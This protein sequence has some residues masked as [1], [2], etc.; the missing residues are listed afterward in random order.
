MNLECLFS[1]VSGGGG[2]NKQKRSCD[3]KLAMS[4]IYLSLQISAGLSIFPPD[5]DAHACIEH[6]RMI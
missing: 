2:L 3:Y 4:I 1:K 5:S 6:D